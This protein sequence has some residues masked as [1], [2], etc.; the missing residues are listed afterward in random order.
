MNVRSYP[1]VDAFLNAA[2][3]TLESRE[4]TASLA[5]GICSNLKTG[6]TYGDH[7]PL[8]VTVSDGEEVQALAVRTPPHKLVLVAED[9]E[10]EAL[11][12][13]AER[14]HAEGTLL[15]GCHGT[16]AVAETFARAWSRR[17]GCDLSVSMRQKI[18]RLDA[19]TPPRAAP[20]HLRHACEADVEWLVD[21]AGAFHREAVPGDPGRDPRPTVDW[22]LA[23][24]HLW[25]WEDERPV[26]ICAALRPTAHGI[27]VGLV[28]TPPESRG[29]GYASNCVAQVSQ[30]LLDEGYDFCTLFTDL[31][32]P[33][34]NKI[35]QAIG[36]RPLAEFCQIEFA[37]VSG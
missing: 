9:G 3:T 15:P 30:A 10:R 32:N 22:M 6:R 29:R 2:G 26:S 1:N 24:R 16:V 14:L 23:H 37:D 25:V 20:G 19:V 18:F 35:Y 31:S 8:F 28:Y 21:W 33:T 27:A 4:D 36:Y 12:A 17:T 11:E 13:L 5:L 34:S 7:P